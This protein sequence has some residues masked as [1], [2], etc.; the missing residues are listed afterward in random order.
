[1]IGFV[2]F[3]EVMAGLFLVSLQRKT[4][5]PPV[6]CTHWWIKASA[7]SPVVIGKKPDTSYTAWTLA[8]IWIE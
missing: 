3:L 4:L 6:S 7:S 1:M 2:F 5:T 8:P